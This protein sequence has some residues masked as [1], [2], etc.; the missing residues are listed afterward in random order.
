MRAYK[1]NTGTETGREEDRAVTDEISEEHRY[2]RKEGTVEGRSV[3]GLREEIEGLNRLAAML[4][5]EQKKAE[6]K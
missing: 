3:E 5:R 4:T 1:R 2:A 6:E